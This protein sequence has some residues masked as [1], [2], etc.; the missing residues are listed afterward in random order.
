MSPPP[1]KAR[2]IEALVYVFD[3]DDRPSLVLRSARWRISFRSR[4]V[5]VCAVAGLALLGTL[6]WRLLPW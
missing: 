1:L 4:G 2:E 6:L 5:V 3:P